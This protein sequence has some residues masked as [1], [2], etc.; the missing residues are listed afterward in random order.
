[1]TRFVVD[2][3]DAAPDLGRRDRGR[4]GHQLQRTAADGFVTSDRDMARAVS[5]LVETA[6]IDA[7]RKA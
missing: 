7:L 5:G 3:A 4:P 1:V 2:A 6:S